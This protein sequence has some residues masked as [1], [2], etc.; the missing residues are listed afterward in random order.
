MR[1]RHLGKLGRF[2]KSSAPSTTFEP[3][4]QPPLLVSGGVLGASAATQHDPI[5][6]W[7]NEN[8]GVKKPDTARDTDTDLL[9]V[10]PLFMFNGVALR[11]L[12]YVEQ[13]HVS[14]HSHSA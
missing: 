14:S 9:S 11:I 6:P 3:Q 2:G 13:A 8:L 12:E 7:I 4:K 5:L 1:F 10:L